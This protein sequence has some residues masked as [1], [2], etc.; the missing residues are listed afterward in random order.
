M[1]LQ[2]SQVMGNLLT[3]GKQLVSHVGYLFHEVRYNFFFYFIIEL[4]DVLGCFQCI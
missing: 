4:S 3:N 2:V 1:K